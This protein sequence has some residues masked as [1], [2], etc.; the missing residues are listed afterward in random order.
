M[1]VVSTSYFYEENLWNSNI[2]R[3]SLG[4]FHACVLLSVAASYLI[5]DLVIIIKKGITNILN[6]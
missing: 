3:I 4:W 5:T 2:D 1:I 6:Q